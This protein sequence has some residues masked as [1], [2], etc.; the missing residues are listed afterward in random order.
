[1]TASTHLAEISHKKQSVS[2]R[3]E[4]GIFQAMKMKKKK[5]K[6]KDKKKKKEKKK[7]P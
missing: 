1:M 3:D 5:K 7:N 6:R 4:T 2:H